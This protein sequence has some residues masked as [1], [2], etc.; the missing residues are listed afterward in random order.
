M[1]HDKL[2]VNSKKSYYD[3]VV[4]GSGP[5]GVNAAYPLVQAGLKVAIV[6]GG[7]ESGDRQNSKS[8]THHIK[9]VSNPYDLLM[10]TGYVFTKTYQLLKVQGNIDIV[11]SLAKG[12]LSEIWHGMCDYFTPDELAKIGLPIKEMEKE[13]AQTAKRSGVS[14]SHALDFHCQTLADKGGNRVYKLP[15]LYPYRTSSV[16]DTLERYKNFTYIPKNLVLRVKETLGN[17]ETETI[18]VEGRNKS[19]IQSQYLI[20]AAGAV[21][22]TRI[23]LQSFRL[24]NY[25]VPFLTKGHTMVVCFH[26]RTL[27][28]LDKSS[29]SNLG[30]VALTC[31]SQEKGLDAYF[32][33]FYR[34]NPFAS[35]M[36]LQYIPL[37]KPLARF[38]FSLIS[39]FLVIADI[40]FPTFKSN[41]KY[42]LLKKGKDSSSAG[43]L[44]VFLKYTDE[45]QAQH[46]AQLKKIMGKLWLLGLIPFKKVNGDITSHYAG[47]VPV[48]EYTEKLSSEPTG[49]LHQ[50][51]RIYVADSA[52]WK[53][54]PGKPPTLTI[55]ANASRVGKNVL[56]KLRPHR[57]IF[58]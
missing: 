48:G 44:E 58:S 27:W 29:L 54:L 40:R 37:P 31:D 15:L 1:I 28:S 38:L 51:K 25:K 17:T 14:S 21:N 36:A 10:K 32:V 42:C 56:R 57:K 23:L 4:V 24:Y 39:P 13:Y 50:G 5:A 55:M 49:K 34:C 26:P 6:D 53:A 30:Q 16:I 41:S 20:L 3:V 9:K 22:T 19:L 47:G 33:Q 52:S 46:K 45:E 43:T 35:E 11:Q 8:L 7:L 2:T 12:G 18:S